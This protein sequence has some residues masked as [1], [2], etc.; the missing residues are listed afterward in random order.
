MNTDMDGVDECGILKTCFAILSLQNEK[1]R[2]TLLVL[3]DN[4]L[5][6]AINV[7]EL[8][9]LLSLQVASLFLQVLLSHNIHHI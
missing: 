4:I 6:L 7:S 8:N 1:K 5:H 2:N 3:F 9:P